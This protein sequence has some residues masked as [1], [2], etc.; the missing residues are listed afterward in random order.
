VPPEQ[1]G[2]LG[3]LVFAGEFFYLRRP[4]FLVSV[5]YLEKMILRYT[6]KG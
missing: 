6:L 4:I 5:I 1:R 3:S 2:I